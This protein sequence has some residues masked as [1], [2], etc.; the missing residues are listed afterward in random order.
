MEGRLHRLEAGHPSMP[1]VVLLHG[2][3]A[4]ASCWRD[5]ITALEDK[6]HVL[7]FDLPGHGGSLNY[8][9]A[10]SGKVASQAVIAELDTRLSGKVHLVG[11]SMGGAVACSVALARPDLVASLTLLSPGGFGTEL[12][13]ALLQDYASAQTHDELLSALMPMAVSG[14]IVPEQTLSELVAMRGV[15]GQREML[16]FIAS[17]MTRDGKQGVLPLAD[18]V[19]LRIPIGLLWGVVDTIVPVSQCHAAPAE[20]SKVVI[21]ETGHMLIDEAP[22]ATAA[23]ILKS[24]HI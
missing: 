16:E 2:F 8:P 1:T 24:L 23:L 9:N 22:A 18:L 12:N 21:P 20:F 6:A 4:I 3:G 17:R 11:H 14:S 7:A 19:A 15:A 13:V 5:V 10:G